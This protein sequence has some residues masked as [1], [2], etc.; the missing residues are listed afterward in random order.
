MQWWGHPSRSWSCASYESLFLLLRCR[1]D[2][3]LYSV[4][5]LFERCFLIKGTFSDKILS[6]LCEVQSAY[7]TSARLR[8]SVLRRMHWLCDPAEWSSE[9]KHRR[10]DN[11]MNEDWRRKM[12][13]KVWSEYWG[14][15]NILDGDLQQGG[16]MCCTEEKLTDQH[17]SKFDF[18]TFV[19]RTLPFT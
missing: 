16:L 11:V 3:T 5:R 10:T 7:Q 2:R 13:K 6:L 8:T 15:Q 12:F 18:V 14:K 9:A 1:S 17:C 19:T 4:H